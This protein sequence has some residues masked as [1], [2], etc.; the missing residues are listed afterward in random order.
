MDL[1]SLKD[2]DAGTYDMVIK[3]SLKDWDMVEEITLS[4]AVEILPCTPLTLEPANKPSDI[5]LEMQE[6]EEGTFTT[7]LPQYVQKPDCGLTISYEVEGAKSWL[8]F[9]TT[10]HSIIIDR[11]SAINGKY[12]MSIQAS[13]DGNGVSL[14]ALDE[15]AVDVEITELPEANDTNSTDDGNSTTN[16][17]ETE[18]TTLSDTAEAETNNTEEAEEEETDEAAE[19]VIPKFNPNVNTKVLSEKQL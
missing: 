9:D 14:E 1:L 4:F 11:K 3:V 6:G 17:T 5:A 15:F 12:D 10:D 18:S 2:S 19:V 16:E 13:I 8:Q 7:A